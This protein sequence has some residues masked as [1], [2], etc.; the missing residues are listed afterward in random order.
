MFN[1]AA[2]RP[3]CS[4]LR[5]RIVKKKKN[6]VLVLGEVLCD[7][8]PPRPGISFSSA[9]ELVPLL[10][11]APANVAVQCA[12]LG[13]RTALVSAVGADPLGARLVK[14]L[15]AEGIDASR[16]AQRKGW[17]TGVTLVE[18]DLDGERRF[19][20][21]ADRRADLSLAPSDVDI[22]FLRT[23][24]AVHTGTVGLREASPRAAH[25]KLVDAAHKA[26]VLVSLDVNL[27]WGM[28]R[29]RE[30][31]LRRAKAAIKRAHVVKATADEARALLGVNARVAAPSLAQRFFDVLCGK[32]AELI[33]IT[34]DAGG[35]LLATR[36]NVVSV[37]APRVAVVDATGAGDAFV[38]AA[39]A[40][41]VTMPTRPRDFDDAQ[42]TELGAFACAAG[43]A[44]C[45]ALGA[46]TAM[47]RRRVAS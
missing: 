20:P 23:F 46:T 4:L 42:L 29:T 2:L 45:T 43:S 44:A 38:G 37:V 39:L 16:V 14:E 26:G 13:A 9:G 12:R 6:G 47:P 11:G 5:S 33:M 21:L 40:H 28:Y 3:P 41:I 30:D 19:Y 27:R 35:A 10:G 22:A 34:L 36:T 32:D 25:K 7:L 17:R 15:A 1:K 18:V 31:L 8:F 24:A